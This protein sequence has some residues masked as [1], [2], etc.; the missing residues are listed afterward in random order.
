MKKTALLLMTMAIPFW[1]GIVNAG[2]MGPINQPLSWKG[3]YLGANAGYGWTDN[4]AR[5]RIPG[6]P[7]SVAFYMP[8][9]N[10]GAFP[11]KISFDQEGF[12]GGVQLGY[13]Y[14]GERMV[15]GLETEIEGAN[16]QGSKTVGLAN[17]GT[18]FVPFVGSAGST[19]NWL[20][21]FRLRGGYLVT[22][23]T[24]IYATGGYAFGGSRD[25]YNALFAQTNDMFITRKTRNKSG[26]IAGAGGEW[27]ISQKWSVKAEY[28][29]YSLGHSKDPSIPAGRDISLVA[30]GIINPLSNVF[31]N[32]GNTI[33]L[34]LNYHLA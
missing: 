22:P 6:D 24:L 8:A 9:I 4:R 26:Y 3:I 18:G 30:R 32:A 28:L 11:T 27:L 7:G 21:D 1:G 15:L 33:R 2:D 31:R 25:M 16:I 14:Q 5:L 17:T 10:A 23:Q 13:N 12:I 20:F 34:G 29:Y 19:L